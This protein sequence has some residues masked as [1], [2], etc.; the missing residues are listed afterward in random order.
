[1]KLKS[2]DFSFLHF[3]PDTGDCTILMAYL[4]YQESQLRSFHFNLGNRHWQCQQH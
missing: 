1:M 4:C 3:L 2:S